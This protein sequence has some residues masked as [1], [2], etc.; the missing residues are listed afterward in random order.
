MV[1]KPVNG[2]G[3]IYTRLD[4]D[5]VKVT[6]PKGGWGA[7]KSDV[8]RAT[9]EIMRRKNVTAKLRTLI[10]EAEA[11]PERDRHK[12]WVHVS[13]LKGLLTDFNE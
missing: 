9:A 7:I 8:A 13:M 4:P 12:H 2:S 5:S 11:R 6:A 3:Y 1:T 10:F